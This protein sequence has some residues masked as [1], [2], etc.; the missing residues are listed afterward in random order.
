MSSRIRKPKSAY[1]KTK[2]QISC[3]VTAPISAFIFATRIVQYILFFNPTFQPSCLFSVISA[4]I[5]ATRIVQSILFFNPTFQPSCLFFRDCTG[6][7]VSDLVGDTNCWFSQMNAQM[8]NWML[9]FFVFV[10]FYS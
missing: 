4:F 5:F 6:R 9:Y 10:I 2:T 8:L 3:A 1:A 7:F